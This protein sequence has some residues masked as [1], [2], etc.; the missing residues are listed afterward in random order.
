MM[1]F[2]KNKKPPTPVEIA[3][4]EMLN[5]LFKQREAVEQFKAATAVFENSNNKLELLIKDLK[6]K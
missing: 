5:E 3:E 4:V 1:F 6:K 2:R